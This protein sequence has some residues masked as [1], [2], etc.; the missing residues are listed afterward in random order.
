MNIKNSDAIFIENALTLLTGGAAAGLLAL[1][2]AI[3]A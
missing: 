2:L 1:I 3:F